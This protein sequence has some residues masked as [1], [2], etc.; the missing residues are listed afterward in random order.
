MGDN[1]KGKIR[2]F[3]SVLLIIT[4]GCAL[5][6][7]ETLSTATK[8]DFD[9]LTSLWDDAWNSNSYYQYQD[10]LIEISNSVI[11]DDLYQ[12]IL[13]EALF[14]EYF[15]K[16]YIEMPENEALDASLSS[17]IEYCISVEKDYPVLRTVYEIFRSLTK[18][19]PFSSLS[20]ESIF[21]D[22]ERPVEDA[23]M[24]DAAAGRLLM[25]RTLAEV[26]AMNQRL[27]K[28]SES[29]GGDV[30]LKFSKDAY[31]NVM[32][33]PAM[34]YVITNEPVYADL[35]DVLD[36]SSDGVD[37]DSFG[38]YADA[39]YR[40]EDLIEQCENIASTKG[41]PLADVLSEEAWTAMMLYHTDPFAVLSLNET[42]LN[43][44]NDEL[45]F[46]AEKIMLYIERI[47]KL[48]AKRES[49]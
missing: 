25:L 37:T 21:S 47:N 48:P 33:K 12:Y 30:V 9:A 16:S 17:T 42:S 31:L 40:L 34:I 29:R 1:M 28:A 38:S 2:R 49:L 15:A 22:T 7:A 5:L 11:P 18:S 3:L 46:A 39:F 26:E 23:M 20:K 10:K 6:P 36:R 41:I 4:A 43:R 27:L 45:E 13:G 32:E 35:R 19:A 8:N 24:P 44:L 14:Y